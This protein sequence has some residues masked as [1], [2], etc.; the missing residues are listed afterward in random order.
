MREKGRWIAE[1]G[2]QNEGKKN[3]LSCFSSIQSVRITAWTSHAH[4]DKQCLWHGKKN[5]TRKQSDFVLN[6]CWMVAM[7]IQP[8]EFSLSVFLLNEQTETWKLQVLSFQNNQQVL[9]MSAVNCN[10]LYLIL[11][12]I[13]DTYVLSI[14][15]RIWSS[16][17]K[18]TLLKDAQHDR[19]W[20]LNCVEISPN[21]AQ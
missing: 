20:E 15:F 5:P 4:T 7:Y 2:K 21:T 16:P 14:H 12:S 11:L 6:F 17:L 1:E 9:E 8:M 19:S 3:T 18:S 13:T 10:Y